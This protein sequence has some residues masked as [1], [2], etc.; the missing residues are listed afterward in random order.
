MK[1]IST[2]ARRIVAKNQG[3]VSVVENN[4]GT[5]YKALE[6]RIT[7][8]FVAKIGRAEGQYLK[9]NELIWAIINAVEDDDE[10]DLDY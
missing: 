4:K 8:R 5:S 6:P 2:I 7:A 10:D 1:K 9:R 3:L